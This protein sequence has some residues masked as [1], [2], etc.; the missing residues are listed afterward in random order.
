MWVGGLLICP[1]NPS[2]LGCGPFESDSASESRFTIQV[3]SGS[4]CRKARLKMATHLVGYDIHPSRGE[5]YDPL[6]DALKAYGN[7]WHHLDSTW[8]IVSHQ[9]AVQVRDNLQAHLPYQD[10]QLLVITVSGDAAAWH[11]FSD[12]GNKWL[13]D[14]L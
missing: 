14:N 2:E 12:A 3:K 1:R 13:K 5:S 6:Y 10:D 8:L 7:W 4:P 11:G 9:T